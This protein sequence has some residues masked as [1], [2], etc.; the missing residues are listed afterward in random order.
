MPDEIKD[1]TK[2]VR[3]QLEQIRDERNLAANTAKRVGDAMLAILSLYENGSFLRKDIPD[4]TA[5]LQ[6]FDNGIKI[7]GIT[8][9]KLSLIHI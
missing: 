1:I 8:I 9:T 3:K 7:G 4:Y 5:F 6:T 2:P